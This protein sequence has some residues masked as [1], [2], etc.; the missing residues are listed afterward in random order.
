MKT[1]DE[2]MQKTALG[3]LWKCFNFNKTSLAEA[4][5]VERQAVYNWFRRGRVSI[6][7]ALI[8]EDHEKVKGIITKKEMRPDVKDWFGV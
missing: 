3:V 8:L 4:A 1:K 7:A 2:E 5:G 6:T